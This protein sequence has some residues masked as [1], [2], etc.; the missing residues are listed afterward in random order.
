MTLLWFDSMNFQDRHL[1]KAQT[2]Y[3]YALERMTKATKEAF[4]K[5]KDAYYNYAKHSEDRYSVVALKFVT[6]EWDLR[7]REAVSTALFVS[8]QDGWQVWAMEG[9]TTLAMVARG[10]ESCVR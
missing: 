8:Y 5:S 6:I 4:H 1:K 2:A 10:C 3:Q 7:D 9:S